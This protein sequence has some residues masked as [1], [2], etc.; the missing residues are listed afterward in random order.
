VKKKKKKKHRTSSRERE[1]LG[2]HIFRGEGKKTNVAKT[3]TTWES[4]KGIFT[5]THEKPGGI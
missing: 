1:D 2:I 5:E 4:K 3:L